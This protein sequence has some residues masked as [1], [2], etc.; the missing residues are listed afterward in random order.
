MSKI[1]GCGNRNTELALI[2]LLRGH[3]IN[4]W[5]R[6]QSIFGKPDFFSPNIGLPLPITAKQTN[7]LNFAHLKEEC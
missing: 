3:H 7:P 5:R 1:R 6:H 4:D 2:K